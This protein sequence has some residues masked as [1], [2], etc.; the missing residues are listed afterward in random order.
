M[1]DLAGW[2]GEVARPSGHLF[3]Y[4]AHPAVILW[5]WDEDRAR[6]RED[7]GYFGRSHVNDTFPG[8]GAVEFQ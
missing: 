1:A 8:R 4:E 2:A 5:T 6:I 7:R 3:V